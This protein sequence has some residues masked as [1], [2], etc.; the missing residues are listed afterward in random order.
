MKH[1]GLEDTMLKAI[2]SLLGVLAVVYFIV[3]GAAN[4]STWF[5]C[6]GWLT[7]GTL[8]SPIKVLTGGGDITAGYPGQCTGSAVVFWILL[9]V[10]VVVPILIIVGLWT[11]WQM[12][13]QSD[14]YFLADLLKREGIA[15]GRE[16]KAKAGTKA[17]LSKAKTIRPSLENPRL[18]D[19]GD[20]LGSSCGQEVWSSAEDSAIVYGPPRSGKGFYL[21][22][23]QI[24]DAPGAVVTTSTRGDNYRATWKLRGRKGPVVLFDPQG[25]SK[26]KSTLK[27]SPLVG[28][29]DALV[30]QRRAETLMAASGLGKS[31]NNQ[32]W[33]QVAAKILM[34]LLHA[35][36]L[37]NVS[38]DELGQ[39]GGSP[40]LA[41][42]AIGILR[43]SP[44]AIR[45]WALLL[46]SE[47]DA[48]PRQLQS[49]WMGVAGALQSLQIPAIA[50]AMQPGEGEESLDIEQFIRDRGTLYLIGTKSGGG[51]VAPFLIALLDEI[52][53]T[54]RTMAFGMPGNRL[55][56]PLKLV[57]DEIANLAPWPGLVQ[58]MADGGG[59]GITP[60]VYLQ[61]G[62]QARGG[63]GEAE[64][65]AIS[66]AAILQIQLGGS[67]SDRELERFVK[68]MGQ[69]EVTE[70]TK[71]WSG[72]GRSESEQRK[73]KDVLTV[74]ELRRLPAGYG[75][76]LNRNSRPIVLKMSRWIDREDADEIKAGIKE[77]DAALLAELTD[78]AN[79]REP[80]LVG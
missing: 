42:E 23:N 49:R 19:V 61:S 52:T 4:L 41:R 56:P 39:W 21:A 48:E 62:A 71:S 50:D 6:G 8:W 44:G 64:A 34:Y 1:E 65:D 17:L 47:L 53:E 75:L 55:D 24:L 60:W 11:L 29:E 26:R 67:G 54:A 73:D 63:W 18:S 3:L 33:A 79:D 14:K 35:A 58:I 2:A 45:S 76:L 51:A 31:D 40:S 9:A 13:K 37:G 80:S 25:L 32:E 43:D 16:I 7:G 59:V 5:T 10:G 46:E 36:R 68:L 78:D 28:C 27:W 77:F 15:K 69:R 66:G 20:R 72:Q 57:L 70:R 30:A 74:A 12:H 22:I 38:M